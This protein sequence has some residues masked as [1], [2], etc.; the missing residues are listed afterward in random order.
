MRLVALVLVL[1]FVSPAIAFEPPDGFRG[2]KWG[3]SREEVRQHLQSTGDPVR[4]YG[5]T[6]ACY[7]WVTMGAVPVQ[8]LYQFTPG[9][10]QFDLASL[11][12]VPA[13]Y[14]AMRAAF[15]QRYG[16]PSTVREYALKNRSG[17]KLTNEVATWNGD[18]VLVR[19]RRYGA[20][21]DAGDA[22]IALKT[23]MERT[24]GR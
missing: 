1:S 21:L 10:D 22:T 13:N 15:E 7:S 6:L 3:A 5:Q 18:G 23:A 12:F 2:V 20:K 19:L 11:S 9:R 14:G 4:C 8:A 16:P 17:E 24:P